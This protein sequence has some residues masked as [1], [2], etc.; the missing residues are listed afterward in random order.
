[1]EPRTKRSKSTTQGVVKPGRG[2][3]GS[4]WNSQRRREGSR[5]DGKRLSRKIL[6]IL[7]RVYDPAQREGKSDVVMLV[8]ADFLDMDPVCWSEGPI[9][10]DRS[11][12]TGRKWAYGIL[13]CMGHRIFYGFKPVII[14]SL[15]RR[16]GAASAANTFYS[17]GIHIHRLIGI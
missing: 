9:S 6:G 5:G 1:M 12:E 17:V 4:C 13:L 2:R 7:R 15:G 14:V 3:N 8:P 10:R 11:N 16:I